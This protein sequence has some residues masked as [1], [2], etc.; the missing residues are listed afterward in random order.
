MKATYFQPTRSHWLKALIVL[1]IILLVTLGMSGCALNSP[2]AKV[3]SV[4]NVSLTTPSYA[5]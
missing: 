4:I 3:S 2:G 1:L 5:L